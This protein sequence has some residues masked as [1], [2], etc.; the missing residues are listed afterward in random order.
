MSYI[1]HEKLSIDWVENE[2]S[3]TLSVPWVSVEVDVRDEDR[4]WLRDATEH[5]H[6]TPANSNV[7]RFINDLK[8]YPIF[9]L[10]PR[11]L[12]ELKKQPLQACPP[13]TV[14]SS[15]PVTFIATFGCATPAELTDNI[16]PVWSWDSKAILS[17]ARIAGTNLYDPLSFVSYL[18]CYRLEWEST[19]WGNQDGF[20]QFLMKLLSAMRTNFPSDWLDC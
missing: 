16:P 9:Y 11:P 4:G 6:S 8:S 12:K 20:E 17:K 10:K 5:L 19:S 13:L 15:T 7:Q 2:Q 14:D 3:F 18:I 1:P